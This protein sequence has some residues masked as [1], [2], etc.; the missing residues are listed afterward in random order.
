M[1]RGFRWQLLALLLSMVVLLAGALFRLSRLEDIARDSSP[2]PA[3]A[4]VAAPSPLP[5]IAG[6][7]VAQASP[8]APAWIYREALTGAVARLNPLLAHLNPVD[9]DISSLIFEGLFASND[10]GE[11][12]P[13]L[14][15]ELVISADGREYVVRLRD[16]IRWHDGIAFDADDVVYTMALLADPDYEPY[17]AASEFWQTVET[18]KLDAGLLRFR[19]AQPFSSFPYLLTIGML[20]AHALEGTRVKALAAHPFNL[21]PIGTGPYQLASLRAN[22][23]GLIDAVELALSPVYRARPEGQNGYAFSALR[24]EL[25]EDA[26]AAI[27][28]FRSGRV[29]GLAN[30]GSRGALLA[31]PDSRIYSQAQSSLATLIFN[32]ADSPFAERRLRQALSLGLDMPTLIEAHFSGDAIFADSPYPPGSSVYRGQA[33][34][35]TQDL[36][37]AETLLASTRRG[38]EE[39]EEADS[40]DPNLSL[41]LL[42][43]EGQAAR[44]L[45]GDIAQAWRSLGID[46]ALELAGI[47]ELD[48][49]L[50]SGRFEAAIV[51]QRI[52]GDFDLFPFWHPAQASAGQNYGQASSLEIAELLEL[53][54]VE[55]YSARRHSMRLQFQEEF[56]NQALAIPLYAPLFTV[57]Q[58]DTIQGLRLGHLGSSADRFRNIRDWRPAAI[59]S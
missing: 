24:F 7:T 18:Q 48:E 56:A 22:D 47:L 27:L 25:V 49:R 13:R 6:A 1:L 11:I 59:A 16:D 3:R 2:T 51:E 39:A 55:V 42:V 54:R 50:R 28:A 17:S 26:A 12:V 35:T 53:A 8:S 40:P 29:D 23:A 4:T 14:A 31:L 5:T 9:H 34:W 36:S 21:S 58:R 32:W 30:I 52:G 33:F 41:S 37:Q 38:A 57:V 19:L 46:V 15:E 45:A 43:G 10:Y 44:A 20:P